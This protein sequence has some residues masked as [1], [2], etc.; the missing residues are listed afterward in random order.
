MTALEIQGR[1]VPLDRQAPDA[2][3]LG[4][5][6]FARQ[7]EQAGSEHADAA[8]WRV[9]RV[10]HHRSRPAAGVRQIDVGDS[11]V[12]PALSDLHSHIA[13]AT[14]PIWDEPTR[15]KGPWLHRDQWP[16]A[17][18]YKPRVSWPAYAYLKGAPEALLAYAQVRALAGGASSIQGWPPARGQPVNRLIRNV[19][20]DIDR[21]AIRTSVVNLDLAELEHRRSLL[22][23][24]KSL[25]YHLAEG[26]RHSKV[27][28]EFADVAM[29]GCLR[30]RLFAIHCCAVGR[31]SFRQWRQNAELRGEPGPGGVIWSPLSNL[32][33]YGQ[34]TDVMAARAEGVTVCLGT[35]W[36]PSGSR[37]LLGELKVAARWVQ[38]AGLPLEAFDLIEM[39]TSNPG[40]LLTR[41][42]GVGPGR[43]EAGRLADAVVV[44]RRHAD[45]WKNLLLARE[46]DIELVVVGGEAVY[47]KRALMRA[48]GQRLTTAVRIGRQS[49]HVPLRRPDAPDQRWTWRAVLRALK[50][51]QADPVAAIER[52]LAAETDWFARAEPT[53]LAPLILESDMPGGLASVAGPPPPGTEFSAPPLPN[54]VHDRAWH[55]RL[56]RGGW[57][58]H[59]LDDL[60]ALFADE[61]DWP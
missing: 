43:F 30:F 39:V 46:Q 60:E 22:D 53:A 15:T 7:D 35:D 47:G 17:P 23:Q 57:H 29:A 20:D 11:W 58:D 48:A 49:R 44:T 50:Q 32:W 19:D 37:N 27:A 12:Y 31:E 25:V 21:D 38:H 1:I 4:R 13:F 45:P 42:W 2:H 8:P 14:L 55:R 34:T 6:R 59:V 51:V 33:L 18:S 16:R 40:D 9:E 52:G 24:H 61:A 5:V 41:A 54:I 26:Q 56:R 36:G 10:R 3:F 28:R